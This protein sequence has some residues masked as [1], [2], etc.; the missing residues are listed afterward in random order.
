MPITFL[1]LNINF[2]SSER[3]MASKKCAGIYGT[4]LARIL[5]DMHH[6]SLPSRMVFHAEEHC[7]VDSFVHAT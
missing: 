1:L 7:C 4:G 5:M 2:P 6:L 3:N